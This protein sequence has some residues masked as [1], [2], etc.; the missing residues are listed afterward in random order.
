[1][2]VSIISAGGVGEREVGGTVLAAG[3]GGAAALRARTRGTAAKRPRT[4][5]KHAKRTVWLVCGGRSL[6][7]AQMLINIRYLMQAY[8]L[9]AHAT[10]RPSDVSF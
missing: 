1:M 6:A 3:V 10:C 8:R 2:N 7:H 5:E 9:P 4:H